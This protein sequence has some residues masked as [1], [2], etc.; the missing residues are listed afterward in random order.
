MLHPECDSWRCG[1]R[2]GEPVSAVPQAVGTPCRDCWERRMTP[3]TVLT[4]SPIIR[5]STRCFRSWKIQH[6]FALCKNSFTSTQT[7]TSDLDPDHYYQEPARMSKKL[8]NCA[9]SSSSGQTLA[10]AAGHEHH[11][12]HPLPRVPAAR[13]QSPWQPQTRSQ[14]GPT[15]HLESSATPLKHCHTRLRG[16]R[17]QRNPR[18]CHLGGGHYP[19]PSPPCIS[20]T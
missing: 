2:S 7:W 12:L 15:R 4:L 8:T 5:Q 1:C 14:V 3:G 17:V 20:C 16:S 13:L 10:H 11:C 18:S 19:L 6:A 9:S